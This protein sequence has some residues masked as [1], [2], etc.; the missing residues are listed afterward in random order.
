MEE[1]AGETKTSITAKRMIDL[2]ELEDFIADVLASKGTVWF[3]VCCTNFGVKYG[4][5]WPFIH[6]KAER[7]IKTKSY[8]FTDKRLVVEDAMKH[9]RL[10]E[11]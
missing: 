9:L 5:H 8:I 6:D 3:N 4:N 7:W 10:K 11:G 2:E 1:G